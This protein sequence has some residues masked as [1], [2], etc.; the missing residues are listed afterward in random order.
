MKFID[1]RVDFAFRKIFGSEETKEVLKSFI[2]AI[3]GLEGDKKLKEIHIAN[4]YQL[5][6]LQLLKIT[7]L[8]VKCTDHR[9]ITYLVEMQI[10][11]T[12]AFLKRVQYNLAKSYSGQIKSGAD[13]PKLN[14]VIGI[15]ITDFTLF[16]RFNHYL[17]CHTTREILTNE[18]YLSDI[19][20]YFLELSKFDKEEKELINSIDKWSYFLKM[21]GELEEIPEALKEAPYKTAFET[22]MVSRMTGDEYELYDNAAMQ[23]TDHKGSLELAHKEGLEEG[24]EKGMEKGMERKSVEIANNLIKLNMPLNQ[25]SQVTGLSIEE[26]QKL[27]Q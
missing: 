17:S 15:T 24:M 23:I 18:E 22:A 16:P 9:G 13:F 27:I 7:I 3:L 1:P 12:E 21:A 14:Q 6:K 10:K 26:I 8:D 2:E 25:I 5:P 19:V 4:P 11:R 20:Y